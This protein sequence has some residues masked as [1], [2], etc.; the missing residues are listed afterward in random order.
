ML[1]RRVRKSSIKHKRG[2]VAI[3]LALGFI[4][5]WMLCMVWVEMSFVSYTSALGD[6]MISQAS[7][8]AKREEVNFK[9][10]FDSVIQQSNSIWKSVVTDDDFTACVRY[11]SDF[12]AL[13]N[14]SSDQALCPEGVAEVGDSNSPIAIYRVSYSFTPIFTNLFGT[15]K[16]VFT[17]EMIVVQE[18]KI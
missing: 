18:S 11:V 2:L 7:S 6:L 10:S 17:R 16:K 12:N 1:K 4:G 9:Q 14:I 13:K 8:Q 3:E 5:F 15:S